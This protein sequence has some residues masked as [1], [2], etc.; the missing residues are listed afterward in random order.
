MSGLL[1][2]LS[3]C[4]NNIFNVA[5]IILT[6]VAAWAGKKIIWIRCTIHI[7]HQNRYFRFGP[8]I[9]GSLGNW[10]TR[11][12]ATRISK[13]EASWFCIIWAPIIITYTIITNLSPGCTIKTRLNDKE[14]VSQNWLRHPAWSPP[15]IVLYHQNALNKFEHTVCLTKFWM[16]ILKKPFWYF[17]LFDKDQYFWLKLPMDCKP[18][19]Q[20][21]IGISGK[22]KDHIRFHWRLEFALCRL[23]WDQHNI[24]YTFVFSFSPHLHKSYHKNPRNPSGKI[25]AGLRKLWKS[26]LIE[27]LKLT[28]VF[29]T[30]SNFFCIT[31]NEIDTIFDTCSCS[32]SLP[33]S[34]SPI[35]RRPRTPGGKFRR[36]WK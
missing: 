29:V 19:F 30:G 31:W 11:K 10:A 16:N 3:T 22:N 12:S 21:R 9:S 32:C 25:P 26:C 14:N 18:R 17:H 4:E 13:S 27:S 34:T 6:P 15:T 5:T 2:V 24:W 20:Y 33:T 1:K 36:A 35:T 23:K 7:V 8:S 28:F